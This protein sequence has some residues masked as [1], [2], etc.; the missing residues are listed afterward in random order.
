LVPFE[1]RGHVSHPD[2]RPRA[3]HGTLRRPNE[4]ELSHPPEAL[5]SSDE[6]DAFF[7]RPI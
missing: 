3:L 1:A 7:A 2:D 5:G 6:L 4:K